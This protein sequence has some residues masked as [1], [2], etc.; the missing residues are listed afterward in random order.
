MFKT[1]IMACMAVLM[2]AGFASCT[3]ANEYEDAKTSNPSWVDNYTDS[4]DIQHPE[5]LANTKWVRG[6]GLKVNVYGE[7][8]QGFVESL[9]FISADAVA[10]KMSEGTTSGQWVDDSNTEDCPYY[11]YTYISGKLTILKETKQDNGSTTKDPIFIG[12]AVLGKQE[13]LTICHYSDSPVQTYLVK[14]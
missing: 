7:E 4:L 13:V 12:Y 1:T 2:G 10:V 9:D 5:T 14:Q 6:T 11:E 8:I 3:D